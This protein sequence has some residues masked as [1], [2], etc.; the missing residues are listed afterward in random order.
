MKIRLL[1]VTILAL[2]WFCAPAISTGEVMAPPPAEVPGLAYDVEFFPGATYDPAVP[3]P[4]SI[5]GHRIGDR[6]PDPASIERCIRAWAE[7]SPRARVVEYARSHEGRPLHYV[8]LTSPRNMERLDEIR[9]GMAR[10]ADPRGLSDDEAGRLLEDLPAVGW[11]AYSIHG[12][13]TSGGDA[14]LAVI[15]HL[16]AST[17]ETVARILDDLVVIVD[18]AQNPD[19]RER[20]YK[21]TAEARGTMPNLDDQSLIHRGYWPSGRGNH[22]LFDLNRDWILGV[23]PETRGRLEAVGQWRPMLMVDGHEMGSQ[24][25][26]LFSPGREPLNPYF[27]ERRWH[28]ASLFA[29][30]QAGA[31]D[32]FGWPYYHGE[33]NEEWYPGYSSWAGFRGSIFILYEQPRVAEDAIRRPSGELVTYGESV[34]H[35]VASTMA[36]LETLHRNGPKLLREFLDERRLVTG[37]QSPFD[38]LY[39]AVLPSG[40]RGRVKAF[41]EL[42]AL[43]GIDVYRT[44]GDVTAGSAVD[45]LGR[46]VSGVTIPAGSLLVPSR[47]PEAHLTAA[48]FEFDPRMN[49]ETLRREREEILLKGDSRIYDITAWNITMLYGLEALTVPGPLPAGV[50]PL[51]AAAAVDPPPV[52]RPAG[53]VAWVVDGADDRS[54]SAAARLMERGVAV[55]V[56]D[57]AFT[58]E[59]RKFGRGSVLVTL[60]DNKSFE[61][62]LTAVLGEVTA[63]L[64]ITALPVATGLGEGDLPDMGGRHFRLLQQPSV[65]L[66]S[67]GRVSSGDFGAIWHALDHDLGI[68]HTHLDEDRA[69]G[70]DLRRYNVIVMPNRYGSQLPEGL[71]ERLAQWVKNGGTLIAIGSSAEALAREESGLSGVRL[72]PDVLEKLDIYE[73]VVQRE[74]LGRNEKPPAAEQVWSHVVRPDL[75]F[76]WPAG[77][78]KPG[79]ALPELEKRDRWQKLFMPQGAFLAGRTDQEDWLTMGCGEILPILAGSGVSSL[80]VLMAADGVA[81]PIRFGVFSPAPDA[82]AEK[83]KDSGRRSEPAAGQDGDEAVQ[84]PPRTGW[85]ALPPG[86]ELRLRMSGLLWPEAAHRLANAAWV[87]RERNGRGQVILFASAPAFRGAALGTGR[88]LMNAIVYGAGLGASQTVNP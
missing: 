5:L 68:R 73:L 9:E 52:T 44:I 83:K 51:G 1:F 64:E 81:A 19:G 45:Q 62:Q 65:A 42:M 31:F 6:F 30:D 2:G 18:P 17:D 27:P 28:W 20:F 26:Y 56:A 24:D 38:A 54:V 58:F 70:A 32:A 74:W 82:P 43:Q 46:K 12:N 67:R 48:L 15:Y 55:Q 3:T 7:A 16:A 41:E 59:D 86:Q 75:E 35:Q 79:P 23:H 66:L 10:L 49:P 76:P 72:L 47:Q 8:I 71:A 13:E 57:R 50:E 80:P 63:G 88:V 29:R 40:N 39:Y 61:G 69:N 36:N 53:T 60:N 37:D 33:W 22:Y 14:A 78:G 21:Q 84:A 34:H 4:E 11:F 87:T 25:T 85:A 77:G